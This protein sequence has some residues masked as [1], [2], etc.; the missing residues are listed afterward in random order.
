MSDTDEPAALAYIEKTLADSYRKEIDQEENVWRSLPFFAATIALQLAA[1]FQIIDK[2]PDPATQAGK[3]SVCFLGLAGIL[4]ILSLCYLA[5]SIYP[6]KFDYI[7]K[8]PALLTYAQDLIKDEQESGPQTH[9]DPFS[10]LVTIKTELARQYAKGADHNR[11]INKRRELRR[12]I[13]GLAALGSVLMAVFLVAATCA[14]YISAHVEKDAAR[15]PAQS[16]SAR[17]PAAKPGPDPAGK[18]D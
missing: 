14:H 10:A 1:L 3:W 16:I 5:A 9:D 8:E 18:H 4:T 11:Q 7:A 2:L 15:A 6:Q 13:A 12:S 17:Q